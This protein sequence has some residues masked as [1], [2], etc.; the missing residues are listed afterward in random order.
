M[1]VPCTKREKCRRK[2]LSYAESSTNASPLYQKGE[3]QE[4]NPFLCWITHHHTF[5][6][7]GSTLFHTIKYY[8]SSKR[9][10]CL[11]WVE[12][13]QWQMANYQVTV[14]VGSLS[15]RRWKSK[16]GVCGHPQR[17]PWCQLCFLTTKIHKRISGTY[18]WL[19][20]F[21][22]AGCKVT[23]CEELEKNKKVFLSDTS[24]QFAYSVPRTT[25]QQWIRQSPEPGL[26]QNHKKQ[27]QCFWARSLEAMAFSPC[28]YSISDYLCCLLLSF[29]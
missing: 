21:E 22:V 7:A 28:V 27:M 25:D 13:S 19:K 1:R 11:W 20:S 10:F 26:L 18:L 23:G 29:F 2:T 6:A 3:M 9:L 15:Q 16:V 24:Q 4:K 5:Q 14:K 12:R 17:W 8:R